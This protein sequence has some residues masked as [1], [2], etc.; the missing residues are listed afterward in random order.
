MKRKMT[1]SLAL[2]LS[3][4]LSLV[5]FAPTAQGQPAQR[6]RFDTG[7]VTPSMGQVL[8][9]TVDGMGGADRIAVRFA[10]RKYMP[11]GCNSEGVCRHMVVS[12]GTT[13]PETLGGDALSFDVQGTGNGVRVVAESNSPNVQVTVQLIDTATGKVETILIALLLP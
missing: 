13:M 11:A 9:L 1:L 5:G 12:Q 10:W 4:L 2:T 6:F 3:M 7:V 8:R